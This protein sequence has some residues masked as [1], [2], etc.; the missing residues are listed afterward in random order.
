MVINNTHPPSQHYPAI[1]VIIPMYNTEKY[2]GDCLESLLAQTFKN[3]EL[4]VV[5]D[6]STDSSPAIVESYVEKFDGRLKLLHMKE[7]SGGASMPRNKGLIFSRGEYIFFTDADDLLTKT[8]LEELYSL[9][10][11]YDADVV[12]CERYYWADSDAKNIQITSYQSGSFV[13]EPTFETENLAERTQGLLNGRFM[14]IIN[15]FVKRDLLVENKILFPRMVSHED[16]IYSWA[17]VFYAKKFLR[18]PNATYVYRMSEGSSTR[19]KR[20]PSQKVNFQIN[21]IINGLS[22]LEEIMSSIDFFKQNPKFLYAVLEFFILVNFNQMFSQSFQLQP[23]E[24]Y[25]TIKQTFGDKLGEHDVLISALCTALNTQQKINASNVQKFNQF[26][27][28]AQK[29]IAEL[30]AQLKKK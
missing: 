5:D 6:C 27:A 20:M 3:F 2:V 11:N 21:C 22:V 4:I 16:T 13:K 25:T 12:Y 30:E 14:G 17:L 8:A 15:K 1:S 9:A 28:Q 23:F 7:N 19:K 26:A 18:V 24:I 10:K 29:R